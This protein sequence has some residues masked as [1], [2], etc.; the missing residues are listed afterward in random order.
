MMA[1]APLSLDPWLV[2]PVAQVM[3]TALHSCEHRCIQYVYSY[4]VGGA[5][6]YKERPREAQRGAR[7]A[8]SCLYIYL[9][10]CTYCIC[11][12]VGQST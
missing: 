11:V 3:H 7:E 10:Y 2:R 8:Q 5:G 4:E 6:R 1:L 9:L 12:F